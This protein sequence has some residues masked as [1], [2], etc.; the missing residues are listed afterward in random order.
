MEKQIQQILKKAIEL[1]EK[2]GDFAIEQAPLILQ[3]FYVWKTTSYILGVLLGLLIISLPFII[4]L[5]LK[6]TEEEAGYQ[7]VKILGR[8][9]EDSTLIPICGL[10]I[11]GLFFFMLNLYYLI[12][13]TVAPKLFLIEYFLK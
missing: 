6:K 3:E 7:E 13:I 2:T 11:I 12:Y 1:A 9:F 4:I 5:F 8:V 10:C